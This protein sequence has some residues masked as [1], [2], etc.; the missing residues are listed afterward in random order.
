MKILPSPREKQR[1]E[2]PYIRFTKVDYV[3]YAG[4]ILSRL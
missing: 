1:E 3:L 4:G 2:E